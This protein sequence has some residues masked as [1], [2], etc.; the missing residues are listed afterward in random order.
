[1]ASLTQLKQ[2]IQFNVNLERLL[3]V[4]KAIAAQQFQSL[5]RTINSHRSL[6]EALE[7][8]V[9]TLGVQQLTHP[10][11][12]GRGPIG[13]LLVTSD[14][15]MLGGLNQQVVLRGLQEYRH[16]PGEVVVVG[17]RGLV[18]VRE[19]QV[20]YRAFA[21]PPDDDGTALAAQVRDHLLSQVLAGRLSQLHLIYPRALSFTTQRIEAIQALPCTAWP[22]GSNEPGIRSRRAVGLESSAA[23]LLEY[24]VWLWLGQRL[25]EIFRMS[26]LAELAARA[27]HLDGSC[28]ELKRREQKLK[29]RYFRE[30]HEV[31]DRGMR[32]LFASKAIY[33]Q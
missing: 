10:Y 33:K 8:M 23:D 2:D 15:G 17:E 22:A 9:R 30:R 3:D 21:R 1:M 29:L 5:E 31:I 32:E 14:T 19:A 6:F 12:Q 11:S 4:L 26:R 24:L 27:I 16:Q 13:V 25:I 28:Q 20:P 18:Y 7:V